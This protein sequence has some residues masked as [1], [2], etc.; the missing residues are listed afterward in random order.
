LGYRVTEHFAVEVGHVDFEH[1]EQP[2]TVRSGVFYDPAISTVEKIDVTMDYFG[3]AMGQ[4]VW[5]KLSVLGL[6]GYS[7]FNVNKVSPHSQDFIPFGE[8]LYTVEAPADGLYIGIG[9]RIELT[10]RIAARLQWTT[11]DA[12]DFRIQSP[13]A[14]LEFR[15]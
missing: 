6:V 1:A 7:R 13:R 2:Y 9:A 5:G 8:G 15:F 3:I 10:N 14:S 11:C 12:A 4:K